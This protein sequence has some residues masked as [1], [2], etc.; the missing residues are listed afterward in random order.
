MQP[1]PT[2][3]ERRQ[4]WSWFNLR[5]LGIAGRR[6]TVAHPLHA[7]NRYV[8]LYEPIYLLIAVLLVAATAGD[9]FLTLRLIEHGAQELNGLMAF[10]LVTNPD[11]FVQSKLLITSLSVIFLTIHKNFVLF[12][13][14]PVGRLL[15]IGCGGYLGLIGY[16]LILFSLIA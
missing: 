6:R 12:G 8:D 10:W 5:H 16:E 2:F 13:L 15:I 4:S 9:A 3:Q 11:Y 1:E 14:L 7:R